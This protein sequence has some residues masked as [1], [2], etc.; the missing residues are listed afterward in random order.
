M[1]EHVYVDE[2]IG[3]PKSAIKPQARQCGD[4]WCHMWCDDGHEKELH[5]IAQQ[6][7]LKRSWF[8]EHRYCSHYDLVPSKRTLA[9]RKPELRQ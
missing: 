5:A 3:Y 7:G 4:K 2:S 6:I 9:L 8:Q 1:S